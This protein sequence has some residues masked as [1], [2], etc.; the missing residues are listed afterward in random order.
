MSN[1]VTALKLMLLESIESFA[2]EVEDT[3]AET[4]WHVARDVAA[5]AALVTGE[6]LD[7]FIV[8]VDPA[9]EAAALSLAERLADAPVLLL[10][11]E[12]APHLVSEAHRLGVAI[13][14]RRNWK[15]AIEAFSGR[16]RESLRFRLRAFADRHQ[17][18]G[19]ER[20]V[21]GFFVEEYD[22]DEIAEHLAI[23]GWTVREHLRAVLVKSPLARLAEVRR[24]V[25]RGG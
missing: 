21:L 9:G 12:E 16:V 2:R 7:G 17:L 14:Y 24:R 4:E 15:A 3:F 13:A 22:R 11:S 8:D 5:A 20:E 1:P 18:T 6:P 19:R 25:R 23:S 10:F